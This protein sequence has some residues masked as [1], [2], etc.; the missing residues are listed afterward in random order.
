MDVDEV[1]MIAN[2][3]KSM[4]NIRE[5]LEQ[6]WD[7]LKADKA[8][9]GPEDLLKQLN[10]ADKWSVDKQIIQGSK[11]GSEIYKQLSKMKVFSSASTNV[12]AFLTPCIFQILIYLG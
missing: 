10:S 9:F 4:A 11:D 7:N 12:S 8:V 6:A 2:I 3:S 5:S 1:C